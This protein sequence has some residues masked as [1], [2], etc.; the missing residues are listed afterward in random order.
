MTRESDKRVQET[1][2]YHE[3]FSA[4]LYSDKIA[5]KTIGYSQGYYVTIS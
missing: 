2:P 4:L 3:V 1:E 5:A